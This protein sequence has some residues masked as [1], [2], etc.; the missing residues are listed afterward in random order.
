MITKLF[1][2]ILFD[3]RVVILSKNNIFVM[4]FIFNVCVTSGCE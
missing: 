3:I 2:S 1:N 4:K